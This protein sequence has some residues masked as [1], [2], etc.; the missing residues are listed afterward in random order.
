[1][2]AANF[3]ALNLAN[4]IVTGARTWE[5]A[6]KKYGEQIMLFKAAFENGKED[7]SRYVRIQNPLERLRSLSA[8]ISIRFTAPPSG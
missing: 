6:R 1:L 2:E 3:L 7:S 5:D 4:E 8:S